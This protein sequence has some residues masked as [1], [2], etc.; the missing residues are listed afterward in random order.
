MQD[1]QTVSPSPVP[2]FQPVTWLA[3]RTSLKMG[4]ADF[5]AAPMYGLFFGAFY[6]VGGLA[7]WK[8]TQSTGQSY[9][10][11]LAVFG[12]PLIGPF[13]AVG[14]YEVSR[15]LENGEPLKWGAVLAVVFRQ[16]DRQV[17]SICMA[18]VM[19]FLFWFFIAHMIFALFLGV[20]SMVNVSTSYDI[21]LT[22]NGLTMLAVGSVVGGGLAFLT[23]AIALFALP[24]LLERELDVIT[25][26][27]TSFNQVVSNSAVLLLWGVIIAGVLFVAMLPAFLGLLVVLPLLGHSSWHLYRLVTKPAP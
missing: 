3:I 7:M 12:F 4:L 2:D 17:P 27:V 24:M 10:L 22:A 23:Y 19:I 6:V 14:L 25:A 15:R 20:T 16:K 1:T 5:M 13:S 11:G 26:T 8:V 18:I 21:F 9:W